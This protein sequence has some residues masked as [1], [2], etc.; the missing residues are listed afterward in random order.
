MLVLCVGSGTAARVLCQGYRMH[1]LQ[2]RAFVA[3]S[4]A[5]MTPFLQ[6]PSIH[7]VGCLSSV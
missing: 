6:H 5:G 2:H 7:C 3:S 4:D 1:L